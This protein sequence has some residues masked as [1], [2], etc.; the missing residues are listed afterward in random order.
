MLQHKE[1]SFEMLASV[2]PETFA[3]YL[4][5]SQRIKIEGEYLIKVLENVKIDM[6]VFVE[7][8]YRHT[9]LRRT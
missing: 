5:F 1:V 3:Q 7:R 6:C 4:E 9:R 2:F 8:Q